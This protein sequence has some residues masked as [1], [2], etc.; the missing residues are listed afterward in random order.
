MLSEYVAASNDTS[1]LRRAL[2][3]AEAELKW[4]NTNRTVTITSPYS[5]KTHRVYQYNVRNSAPRPESYLQ[6]EP[7]LSYVGTCGVGTYWRL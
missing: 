7:M 5:N 2:P 4:W 3:L 1:I 6:G